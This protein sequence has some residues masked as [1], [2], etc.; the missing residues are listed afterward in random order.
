MKG[1]LK[2]LILAVVLAAAAYSVWSS[3]SNGRSSKILSDFAIEDTASIGRIFIDDGQGNTVNLIRTEGRFWVLNDSLKAM[4][5]HVLLLLKTFAGAG[6]QSPVSDAS[7]ENVM[8]IILAD[9]RRVEVYDRNKKWIKT[10]YVG[11]STQ[12]SQGTYAILETPED[13]LSTEP[14]VIE[15]RG[16]R[17]YLTTRFHADVN[18]WRWSGVFYHP[19]LDISSIEVRLPKRENG[20]FKI[21]IPKDRKENL[22]MMTLE[23]EPLEAPLINLSTYVEQFKTINVGTFKLEMS[24]FQRDSVLSQTPDFRI[25]ITDYDG[26]E[27]SCDIFF[28]RPPPIYKEYQGLS[29]VSFDP[30][31]VFL[32]F[33][34]ELALGQRP[35]FD[36]IMYGRQELMGQ[37][38]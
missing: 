34:G 2:Y 10:W 21:L 30:E 9:N 22:K 28:K 31:R 13:G 35:T 1:N 11:R 14:F 32:Y 26:N 4:P 19:K 15:M 29:D 6:V 16:F 23:G 25:H 17:G 12:N 20:D 36:K 3:N 7:R 24:D 27:E 18:D 37:Q 8:R 38:P 33:N 5:H